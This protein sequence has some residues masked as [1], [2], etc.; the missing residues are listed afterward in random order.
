[1]RDV[2]AGGDGPLGAYRRALVRGLRLGILTSIVV[3]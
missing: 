2:P 1:M 3:I